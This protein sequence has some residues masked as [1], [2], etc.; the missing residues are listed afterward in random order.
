MHGRCNAHHKGCHASGLV[1][2][3]C[4][5]PP[6]RIHTI[7]HM[8]CE[9]HGICTADLG[10]HGP[11]ATR[12]FVCA[13]MPGTGFSRAATIH[14]RCV[15]RLLPVGS[16]EAS[17]PPRGDLPKKGLLQGELPLRPH[18]GE[19]NDDR[20]HVR[21]RTALID[22]VARLVRPQHG[23]QTAIGEMVALSPHRQR[24]MP[25]DPVHLQE[26]VAGV[27]HLQPGRESALHGVPTLH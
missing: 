23:E 5:A 16:P 18:R 20:A 3:C 19:C 8:P 4:S 1:A 27:L 21:R 26:F 22:A 14:S 15:G 13:S 12:R 25:R 24:L 2:A 9:S 7:H 17:L 10:K 11:L 6:I